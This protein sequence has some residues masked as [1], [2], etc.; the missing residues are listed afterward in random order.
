MSSDFKRAGEG[1]WNLISRRMLTIVTG[2]G[3]RRGRKVAPGRSAKEN[4]AETVLGSSLFVNL[5]APQLLL[6]Q[7]PSRLQLRR[8]LVVEIRGL[9]VAQV[10]VSDALVVPGLLR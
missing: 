8:L 1:G 7:I 9:Q 2:R 3:F 5:K 10:F 4:G 6:R